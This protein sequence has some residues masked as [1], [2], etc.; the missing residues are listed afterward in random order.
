MDKTKTIMLNEVTQS[1]EET[2]NV[3][4]YQCILDVK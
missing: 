2:L 4:T 3:F 1:Q